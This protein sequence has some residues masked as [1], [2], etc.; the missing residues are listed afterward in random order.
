MCNLRYSTFGI[1][2]VLRALGPLHI[3]VNKGYFGALSSK[4]YCSR[5]AIAYLACSHLLSTHPTRLFNAGDFSPGMRE[6]APDTMA[7]SPVKSKAFGGAIVQC[8]CELVL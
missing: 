6:P 7:T 8:Q 1:N 3:V 2:H 4:E 5:A